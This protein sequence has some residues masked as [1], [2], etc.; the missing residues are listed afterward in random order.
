MNVDRF[1]SVDPSVTSGC[2][3]PGPW[4]GLGAELFGKLVFN[5]ALPAGQAPVGVAGVGLA[6]TR[7]ALV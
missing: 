4:M 2:V 3:K 5:E 1:A 7:F 6:N